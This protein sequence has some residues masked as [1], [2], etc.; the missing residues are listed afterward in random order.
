[1]PDNIVKVMGVL[2][3]NTILLGFH[4]MGI[5][6]F[7]MNSYQFK[8]IDKAK[9]WTFGVVNCITKLQNEFW[10][11]TDGNGIVDYEFSGDKRIRN[12]F[13][14]AGF[15]FKKSKCFVEG[16]GRECLGCC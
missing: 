14:K 12:F 11:G 2:P 15:P 10:L 13:D 4:Q 7:D 16:Y 5:A 6:V 8:S 9:D 3:D 1:M